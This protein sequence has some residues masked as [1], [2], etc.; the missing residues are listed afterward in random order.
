M[1]QQQQVRKMN[2]Y[3]NS[4]GF[5]DGEHFGQLAGQDFQALGAAAGKSLRPHFPALNGNFAGMPGLPFQGFAGQDEAHPQMLN[6]SFPQAWTGQQP[7]QNMSGTDN[8]GIM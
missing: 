8:F 4:G 7:S 1:Q 6:G 3:P 5:V 2:H